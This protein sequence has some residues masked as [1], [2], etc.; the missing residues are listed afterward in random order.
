V[1]REREEEVVTV[2]MGDT[3]GEAHGRLN[4][5]NPEQRW[6]WRRGEPLRFYRAKDRRLRSNAE[7][8]LPNGLGVAIRLLVFGNYMR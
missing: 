3:G 1:L 8:R 2:T 4:D 5:Q 7:N 6:L